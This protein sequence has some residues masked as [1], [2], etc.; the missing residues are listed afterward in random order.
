MI[1]EERKPEVKTGTKI[2]GAEVQ[3]ETSEKSESELL[4]DINGKL[5]LL[6]AAQKINEG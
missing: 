2:K 4:Q 5:D 6:L 3:N 1:Q